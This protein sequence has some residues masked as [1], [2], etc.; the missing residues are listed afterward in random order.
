MSATEPMTQERLDAIQE[1]AGEVTTLRSA[2]FNDWQELALHLSECVDDL[3]AE[4][5]RLRA[6]TTVDKAMVERAAGTLFKQDFLERNPWA[7]DARAQHSLEQVRVSTP[8]AWGQY[9]QVVRA[10]LDAALDTGED[11]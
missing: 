8:K 6:L 4:V 7:D 1:R 11:A 3:L 5:E 10:A 2:S 9:L